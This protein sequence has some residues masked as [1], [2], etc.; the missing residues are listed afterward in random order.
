VARDPRDLGDDVTFLGSQTRIA[1][2]NLQSLGWIAAIPGCKGRIADEIGR[3]AERIASIATRRTR[4]ADLITRIAELIVS[5]ADLIGRD[6][7]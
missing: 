3:I 4:I 7:S 5:I 1:A 6:A 2:Q